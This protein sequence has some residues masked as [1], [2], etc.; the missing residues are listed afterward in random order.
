MT[1]IGLG[2]RLKSDDA[3]GS[4]L[5]ERLKKTVNADII[6]AEVS[7]ENYL[8]KV[9]KLKP[10]SVIVIDAV[11][12]NKKPGTA[13]IIKKGEL[14]EIQFSTHGLSLNYFCDYLSNEGIKNIV[15]IGIQPENVLLGDK[16][17]PAVEKGIKR[18]EEILVRILDRR[19]SV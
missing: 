7:L 1:V 10:D 12:M 11:F 2:N 16:I 6:D 9:V 5:A 14:A 15:I 3:A 13:V 19:D 4:V 18:L 8:G 17:S